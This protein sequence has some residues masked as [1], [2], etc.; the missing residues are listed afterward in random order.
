MENL[1]GRKKPAN[2]AFKQQN[3]PACRPILTP[4]SVAFIFLM[5]GIPFV[6]IGKQ[7][8]N[9]SNKVVEVKSQYDG[10]GTPSEFS[11][12]RI[13]SAGESKNCEI[14]IKVHEDVTAPVYLY[15]QLTN[16]YQ[17]HRKYVKSM[18]RA[19]LMGC[20]SKSSS[21]KC[22]SYK[23]ETMCDPLVKNGSKTLSPCGLIAN[24]IFNDVV[25]VTSPQTAT[26]T[27]IA[28]QSDKNKYSQPDGF[29]T[30]PS[31]SRAD[32]CAYKPALSSY[33]S[34]SERKISPSFIIYSNFAGLV[35]KPAGSYHK[36]SD[37][38]CQSAFGDNDHKGCVAYTC[39]S[40]SNLANYYGCNVGESYI[41]WYPEDSTTQ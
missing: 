36:C 32:P 38:V 14:T 1:E 22:A 2:T 28:W 5:V 19:Q 4:L 11:A 35:G 30:G 12:C 41:S 33:P 18:D 20:S 9:E 31:G 6:V 24:S 39:P 27:G 26:Y 23:V 15:Y 34:F 7:I 37:S 21:G 29:K 16:F 17:N 10:A 3:L 8:Q 13:N 25:L 40:D